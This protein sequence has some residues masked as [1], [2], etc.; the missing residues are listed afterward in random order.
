MPASWVG[1]DRLYGSKTF[2][3]SATIHVGATAKPSRNAA[4]DHTFE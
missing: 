2:S 4:I 1:T 3:S